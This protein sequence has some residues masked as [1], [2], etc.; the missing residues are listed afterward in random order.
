[1][2]QTAAQRMAESMWAI[3]EMAFGLAAERAHIDNP[4]IERPLEEQYVSP[5]VPSLGARAPPCLVG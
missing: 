4:H 2:M 5:L 3:I 1:M